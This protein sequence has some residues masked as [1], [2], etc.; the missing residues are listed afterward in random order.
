MPILIPCL[1]IINLRLYHLRHTFHTWCNLK[2]FPTRKNVPRVALTD[3]MGLFW[4][5]FKLHKIKGGWPMVTRMK[6]IQENNAYENT[7]LVKINC[8]QGMDDFFLIW[9][10]LG[11]FMGLWSIVGKLQTICLW[12]GLVNK[13]A[14][15]SFYKGIYERNVSLEHI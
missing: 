2:A 7:E 15:T 4:Q 1:V 6:W 10:C 11:Q 8:C 14:N 5:I 9:E 13:Y 12:V 3:N